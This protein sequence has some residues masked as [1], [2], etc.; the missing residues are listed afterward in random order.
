M[1]SEPDP[2]EFIYCA[3]CGYGLSTATRRASG[4]CPRCGHHKFTINEQNGTI[5]HRLKAAFQHAKHQIRKQ[6]YQ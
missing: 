1:T 3:Y 5:R 4:N 6:E 2:I